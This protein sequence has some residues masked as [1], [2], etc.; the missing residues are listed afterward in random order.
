MAKSLVKT[1]MALPDVKEDVYGALDEWAAFELAFPIVATR[2][3]LERLRQ[4]E[5]WHKIIQVSKWMLSKGL[6]KTHGTYSLMLKAY[7]MDGRLENAEALWDKILAL[8]TRSMPKNMFA[9]MTNVYRRHEMPEKVIKV[10][11]QMEGFGIKPD[12]DLL[13]RIGEA[14]QQLGM[15]EKKE[16][17]I[18]KYPLNSKT[19]RNEKRIA[20]RKALKASKTENTTIQT[21]DDEDYIN[22]SSI[23][24]PTVQTM[25]SSSADN[26][27][28][29]VG[30]F[31]RSNSG[32]EESKDEVCEG[33]GTLLTGQAPSRRDS[34]P[35]SLNAYQ[36][37]KIE[38][39][40]ENRDRKATSLTRPNK[41]CRS[42]E[43]HNHSEGPHRRVKAEIAADG[44]EEF[45]KRI[46]ATM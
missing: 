1:V 18:K 34:K 10:F 26:F 32:I 40:N 37:T 22:G 43:A 20:A 17:L 19:R 35:N 13:R 12:V 36:R 46:I 24:V 39:N 42:D 30:S 2:K 16:E 6:G 14:Y 15:Q 25:A 5:Q 28:E 9:Y 23:T 11:E 29:P 45:V 38:I 7:C 31:G 41:S 27:L 8:H 4:Q 21:D 33:R 3:A 44:D